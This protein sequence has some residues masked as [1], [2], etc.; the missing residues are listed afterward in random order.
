MTRFT[1]GGNL[2]KHRDFSR[3]WFSE[4]VSQFGNQFT[5]F[6]LPVLAVL[7]FKA[8]PFDMGLLGTFVFLPYPVLGLFVGVLADRLSKR[9]IMIICN[10][11]RMVNLASIPTSFLLGDLSLYQLFAVALINGVFSVFFDVSYQAYLPVLIS[12]DDLIEGNQKLQMSV[13]GAQVAGPGIAGVVY[14][15]IGGALTIAFD[16]IGYLVSAISLI[17]IR[18]RED[19]K[20]STENAEPK[21]FDEMKE[22]IHA[23]LRNPILV[24]IAGST[25]TSNLGTQVLF[26]VF[27]IYALDYLHFSPIELGLVGTIG[28]VG[29]VLGVLVS[30]KLTSRFGI[31]R[32]LAFS[33]ASPVLWVLSP[34]ALYGFAFV[35]LSGIY[36]VQGIMLPMYNINAVSLRQA[37]TPDALQGRVNATN[38]TIVWGTIPIGSFVGGILGGAIGVVNTL[39]FGGAV[40]GL[41]V[42]WILLGPVW[43][44]KVIPKVPS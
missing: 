14:Q 19:R 15:Y 44:L 11:G 38:R 41:A 18:K 28:A 31:G 40:A 13:S 16:S 26:A 29:F 9:K 24:R 17:T 42:L 22:G 43:Q 34:L 32:I 25:A 6:A 10:L 5:Q 4:T 2:W 12:H 8:S 23:V 3:L 27:T 35:I 21:F 36:F 39:Y 20:A 37:I 7:S 30:R 1:L 33:I